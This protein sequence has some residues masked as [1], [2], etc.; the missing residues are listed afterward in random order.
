MLAACAPL[1]RW[2]DVFCDRGAFDA[3]E[4]RAVLSAGVA[5]GLAVRLHG[6]QLGDGPGAPIAAEYGA[7]SLDHGTLLSDDDIAALR[8]A[9]VVVTLLPGAEFSTRSPYPDAR[10]LI[11]AGLTVALATDCNPGS[12]Y[13]TSMPFMIAL[14]VREMGMTPAEALHAATAEAPPRC[15]GPTSDGSLS[16]RERTSWFSARLRIRTWGIASLE[17]GRRDLG[18]GGARRPAGS[19]EPFVI[20]RAVA[21]TGSG[22]EQ[23]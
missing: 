18:R 17:P 19:R 9:G 3:E 12:S 15:V 7:A 6:N 2:I 14:A 20:R 22:R 13:I 5:A 8:D 1:A 21:G 10:R 4:T 11:D 23:A 16:A